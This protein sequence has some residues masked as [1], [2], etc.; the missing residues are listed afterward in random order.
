MKNYTENLRSP[1]DLYELYERLGW[2]EFLQLDAEQLAKAMEGS[3]YV[4][5]VYD[6]DR[7][8]GTGRVVSDGV[9]NAYLCGLGVDPEYRN[10][11]VGTRI[12][13]QLVRRCQQS[14]LHV[15][16]FCEE[17]LVP[18]YEQCG[19]VKFAV[20]MKR[21]PNLKPSESNRR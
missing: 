8:I 3:W 4:L 12:T 15:Q 5:Y 14:K 7:L 21:G 10:L 18:F 6:G 13:E 11:G 17:P 19:F 2:A 20:G 9:I 1:L 16:F